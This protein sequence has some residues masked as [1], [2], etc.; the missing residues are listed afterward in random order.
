[1][2]NELLVAIVGNPNVGKTA[3][4]NKIAGQKL[5]VGNWPGVTVEKKEAVIEF[6][7]KKLKLVDLPGIYSL[8]PY[9][10]EENIARDFV[11]EENPDFI[12][13]VIDST[14]L[15]RNL[16]LTTQLMELEIPMVVALNMWDEFEKKGYKIDLD[17][18]KELVGIDVVPT[19]GRTGEGVVDL[20]QAG[21]NAKVPSVIRYNRKVETYIQDS[22]DYL[23]SYENKLEVDPRWYAIKL[24]EGDNHTLERFESDKLKKHFKKRREELKEYFKE[25][26][27]SVI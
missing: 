8:S 3:I 22:I 2:E 23:V 13:N 26:A 27:E 9:S 17:L 10:M 4:L 1:M 25:D 11:I 20:F 19:V 21:M 6:N 18:F 12:V 24:L 5:K 7:G 15:E 14:N 16:Y